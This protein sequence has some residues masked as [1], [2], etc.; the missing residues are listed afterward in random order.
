MASTIVQH[1]STIILVRNIECHKPCTLSLYGCDETPHRTHRTGVCKYYIGPIVFTSTRERR[2]TGH[3]A[4]SSVH[5]VG[6]IQHFLNVS[7][8]FS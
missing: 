7:C 1:K 6:R 2:L 3:F 8:L 5:L 4:P